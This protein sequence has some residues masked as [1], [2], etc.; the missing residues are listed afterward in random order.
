MSKL[1]FN[2]CVLFALSGCGGGSGNEV[3]EAPNEPPVTTTPSNSGTTGTTSPTSGTNNTAPVNN[4]LDNRAYFPDYFY[5]DYLDFGDYGLE[6]TS[7]TFTQGTFIPPSELP[8]NSTYEIVDYSFLQTITQGTH[9]GYTDPYN[10]EQQ[11][12]GRW[13]F[14]LNNF[15]HPT[16]INNDG[17]I[18]FF[19]AN[20]FEGARVDRPDAKLFAMINDGEGHFALDTSVFEDYDFM[21]I[22]GGDHDVVVDPQSECGYHAGH[23]RMLFA[24]FNGDGNDDIFQTSK[25]ILS[26]NGVMY[27]VSK[28]N[29]PDVF[30]REDRPVWVHDAA[31]IDFD[32][33][34]DIDIFLPTREQEGWT[35]LENDGTG[36][37][38]ERTGLTPMLQ[39]NINCKEMIWATTTRTADFNNDGYD[40]I[41]VG[42]F[43]PY[44]A[45]EESVR[46]PVPENSAGAI[47]LN[48]G[49]NSREA[50]QFERIIPLPA[51]IY[52]ANGN[53]NHM[54]I[55]DFNGDF[56]PDIVIATTK[57]DPYYQGRAIQFI[58]TVVDGDNISFKDVT[59]QYH[60][61]VDKYA[62]G[63]VIK[64]SWWNGEGRLRIVDVDGDGD[65]DIVD[66]SRESYILV[67]Q[68]YETFELRD[69]FPRVPGKE[70]DEYY[71][72][73]VDQD[74]K[75]DFISR[76]WS[77]D[78]E[79][80]VNDFFIVKHK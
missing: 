66:S 52:G 48:S 68:N 19:A 77:E 49:P 18:D 38:T 63:A 62:D 71:P 53:A 11:L 17:H 15:F 42:W 64:P 45:S 6:Y 35:I 10:P 61:S 21:C 7:V 27:D 34:G 3:A 58:Q 36:N 14:K 79:K 5:D 65:M 29:L 33:D 43:N 4:N 46:T 41:A 47:Y 2:I 67:N 70:F 73:D 26:N 20:W 39:C 16:D 78:A 30:F 1:F 57:H 44:E 55:I 32:T 72:I 69:N 54:E 51:N 31:T 13:E 9:Y 22:S 75:M 74:G 24:D 59:E 23:Q 37:F 40:D 25:L 60:P 8:S 28:S 56:Y 12:P 80:S 50:D 76:S